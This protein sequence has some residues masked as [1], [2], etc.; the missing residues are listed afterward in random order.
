MEGRTIQIDFEGRTPRILATKAVSRKD[1]NRI[2]FAQVLGLLKWVSGYRQR[3]SG[4]HR[5][6][7][8]CAPQNPYHV[9]KPT[10][11]LKSGVWC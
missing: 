9:E 7:A 5:G 11:S 1:P 2:R 8:A 10:I 6:M 4:L 3:F